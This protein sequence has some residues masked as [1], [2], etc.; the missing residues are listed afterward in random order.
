MPLE[1]ELGVIIERRRSAQMLKD[2]N[3]T[4]RLAEFVFTATASQSETSARHGR[5]HAK[6]QT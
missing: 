2:E 1:G 4:S 3:G 6:K 5:P